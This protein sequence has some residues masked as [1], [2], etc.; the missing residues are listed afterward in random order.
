MGPSYEP[1]SLLPLCQAHT[2]VDGRNFVLL[3]LKAISDHSKETEYYFLK[4]L[5]D[6]CIINTYFSA[7]HFPLPLK[8]NLQTIKCI[9]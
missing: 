8:H 3:E 5:P 4:G 7:F 2:N 1:F 6:N 9:C